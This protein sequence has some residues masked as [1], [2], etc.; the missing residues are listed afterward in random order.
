M[1]IISY[2][3]PFSNRFHSIDDFKKIETMKKVIVCL[4]TFFAGVVTLPILCM[5]G[6]A[7]FRYLVDRFKVIHLNEVDPNSTP[8]R[9]HRVAIERLEGGDVPIAVPIEEPAVN[10]VPPEIPEEE[11]AVNEVPPEIPEEE[12]AVNE[13]PPEIPEDEPAVYEVPTKKLAPRIEFAAP[14]LKKPPETVANTE[15]MFGLFLNDYNNMSLE[16]LQPNAGKTLEYLIHELNEIKK[17][18]E[19]EDL[20]NINLLLED[21]QSAYESICIYQQIRQLLKDDPTP[22]L[23]ASASQFLVE[24]LVANYK[25]T[26]SSGYSSCSAGHETIVHLSIIEKDNKQYVTGYLINRGEGIENHNKLLQ[27]LGDKISAYIRLGECLLTD[28]ENS[29]FL[30]LLLSLKITKVPEQSKTVNQTPMPSAEAHHNIRDFYEV[31]L[32][33]WPGKLEPLNRAPRAPQKGE[34]C[35]AKGYITMLKDRLPGVKGERIKL[36]LNKRILK[37]Y[38]KIVGI[39]SSNV[40]HIKHALENINRSQV[41]LVRKKA[42][43]E[44]SLFLFNLFSFSVKEKINLFINDQK[45][46]FTSCSK[47]NPSNMIDN[48]SYQPNRIRGKAFEV[49]TYSQNNSTLPKYHI[50]T[51]TEYLKSG[52]EIVEKFSKENQKLDAKII[53]LEILQ[54]IP[55]ATDTFWQNNVTKEH[56]KYLSILSDCIIKEATKLD[57]ELV[58]MSPNTVVFLLKNFAIMSIASKKF[59]LPN[60][61]ID[62]YVQTIQFA[63]QTVKSRFLP[64]LSSI[65]KEYDES[66]KELNLIR[67][68]KTKPYMPYSSIEKLDYLPYVILEKQPFSRMDQVMNDP[69]LKYLNSQLKTNNRFS[70]GEFGEVESTIHLY[71]KE[72]S[73]KLP[74]EFVNLR[75]QFHCLFFGL[76]LEGRVSHYD[77]KSS[78]RFDFIR[79]G[80][81]FIYTGIIYKETELNYFKLNDTKDPS[82]HIFISSFQKSLSEEFKQFVLDVVH[83]KSKYFIDKISKQNEQLQ[84][85]SNVNIEKN[86]SISGAEYQELISISLK[87]QTHFPRLTEYFT[88][89][90]WR[91]KDNRFKCLF[92]ML[93]FARGKTNPQI[94]LLQEVFKNNLQIKNQFINFFKTS[95]ERMHACGWLNEE[96]HLLWVYAHVLTFIDPESNLSVHKSS[97]TFIESKLKSLMEKTAKNSKDRTV[98]L[99]WIAALAPSF[100]DSPHTQN[101]LDYC[102]AA[103]EA[104]QKSSQPHSFERGIQ[105]D[106]DFQLLGKKLTE[107]KGSKGQLPIAIVTHDDFYFKKRFRSKEVLKGLFEFLGDDRVTYR[108]QIVDSELRLFRKFKLKNGV[109]DWFQLRKENPFG[110]K[111][112][113]PNKHPCDGGYLTAGTQNWFHVGNSDECIVVSINN[114]NI[115]CRI[116]QNNIEKVHEGLSPLFLATAY[117]SKHPLI[118]SILKVD[119][120]NYVLI[121][122]NLQDEI[123]EIELPHYNETIKRVVD[124]T[125]KINTWQ[126]TLHPGYILDSTKV[127][128]QLYPYDRYLILTQKKDERNQIVLLPN[129]I[130][131]GSR[132]SL[133]EEENTTKLN[134]APSFLHYQLNKKGKIEIPNDPER[135]VYLAYLALRIKNYKLCTQVINKLRKQ[136][137]R[138]GDGLGKVLRTLTDDQEHQLDCH[139]KAF[140]LKLQLTEL[141]KEATGI[142]VEQINLTKSALNISFTL[143]WLNE[144][145]A[146]SM[147]NNSESPEPILLKTRPGQGFIANFLYY[148]KIVRSLP[149]TNPKHKELLD[150]LRTSRFG[151][152]V[153]V[154]SLRR[155]LLTVSC[156][157][158]KFPDLKKLEEAI[159]GKTLADFLIKSISGLT[160]ISYLPEWSFEAKIDSSTKQT[161]SLLKNK[162]SATPGAKVN[163]LPLS[164]QIERDMDYIHLFD[165]SGYLYRQDPEDRKVYLRKEIAALTEMQREVYGNAPVEDPCVEKEYKRY[166]GGFEK[167][168]NHLQ[169]QLS[170]GLPH[171]QI[172]QGT[173]AAFSEDLQRLIREENSTLA[174]LK[175]KM[176][177]ILHHYPE[178]LKPEVACGLLTPL[179]LKELIFYFG[180]ED[181]SAITT[182][183]PSLGQE[184]IKNCKHLLMQYLVLSTN[185]NQMIHALEQLKEAQEL[186]SQSE[187]IFQVALDKVVGTLSEIRQ[188]QPLQDPTL[189]VF[190]Y[191][192]KL[193][194]RE[195]QITALK[196]LTGD[197]LQNIELEARTGFGKSK[198]LIPLW[199][200]L[201]SR[202]RPLTMMTVPQSLF[203]DQLKHLRKILGDSFDLSILPL[204]ITRKDCSNLDF[205]E[206]LDKKL[207]KAIKIKQILLI[208]INSLH[209]IATLAEKEALLECES[210]EDE[211]KCNA[212]HDARKKL[213]AKLS[214]FVD[215]SKEC[216]DIRRRYD[217][218]IGSPTAIPQVRCEKAH[219]FFEEVLFSSE[220]MRKWNFEFLPDSSKK[221]KA[222]ITDE[223]YTNELAHELAQKGLAWLNIPAEHRNAMLMNLKGFYTTACEAYF[224]NCTQDQLEKIEYVKNQISQFLKRTLIRD[225]DTRYGFN[226]ATQD[227]VAI[228]YEKGTP[229][230]QSQ[231]STVDDVINFTIQANLKHPFETQHVARYVFDLK[232]SFLDVEADELE[233]LPIIKVL[234]QL[235]RINRNIPNIDKLGEEH[236]ERILKVINDPKMLSVKL[237]FISAFVLPNI[238]YYQ[239]KISSTSFNLIRT[240][241]HVNAASGTVNP[242]TLPPKITPKQDSTAPINNLMSLWKNSQDKLFT[243]PAANSRAMLKKTL[244]D[245]SDY[246]VIVDAAGF[247]RELSQ[248]QIAE[249]ILEESASWPQPVNAVSFYDAKGHFMVLERNSTKPIPY[250]GTTV[251]LEEIF[252]F[253]R[254]SNSIGADTPMCSNAKGLITMSEK[255]PK[256]LFLQ[257]VGRMRGLQ[258]GQEAG[259]L[260]TEEASFAITGSKE[261][262]TLKPLLRYLTSK[263]GLKTGEDYAFSLLLYL[264]D[265]L[266][267]LFMKNI[268]QE[269]L[270]VRKALFDKMQKYLVITTQPAS[271]AALRTNLKNLPAKEAVE[272]LL[273]CY[274]THLGDFLKEDR[275][276]NRIINLSTIK[277][278]F[279]KYL[280]YSKLPK[281]MPS[282]LDQDV[283]SVVEV[284]ETDTEVEAEQVTEA[285]CETDQELEME[286]EQQTENAIDL[287]VIKYTPA[288]LKKWDGDYRKLFAEN[289]SQIGSITCFESPNISFVSLDA[290]INKKVRKP[291]YQYVIKRDARTKT[292]SIAMLDIYDAHKV[293]KRMD[294]EISNKSSL[295][296]DDYFVFSNNNIIASRAH[297]SYDK[298]NKDDVALRIIMKLFVGNNKLLLIEQNFLR[299]DNKLLGDVIQTARRL[300]LAW[301]HMIKL[302]ELET[303]APA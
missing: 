265:I 295:D 299:Q 88:K 79:N 61:L 69:E 148:Y 279:F 239:K 259:L 181:D 78:F 93:I 153:K 22:T 33:S 247:F 243:L 144:G 59:G 179:K 185:Q 202:K 129:R 137:S 244:Q 25:L 200:L 112:I 142:E 182:S 92:E 213:F 118:K 168:I 268:D 21:Y 188:Y 9:A 37:R 132:Q 115:L 276:L 57:Q 39:N 161:I 220:I 50:S 250:D 234:R 146:N 147:L 35:S 114:K 267:G 217:Y 172:H 210:K 72:F 164:D 143:E 100:S 126:S 230:P 62:Y 254:H 163:Q 24:K 300:S 128:G 121:W 111:Y 211:K 226:P 167:K 107:N 193:R 82:K 183:N 190:E 270:K 5:G 237:S 289:G 108:V 94:S 156:D 109:Q 192:A 49:A 30:E 20:E 292:Y 206:W 291:A 18:L 19:E 260:L 238:T 7:T 287:P 236:Y 245:H 165:D 177:A 48:N 138:W 104:I 180:K 252:T 97:V 160:I 283:I 40:Q 262:I 152:D 219:Q 99:H 204:E 46:R 113:T 296:K 251:P 277:A 278:E 208:S 136:P 269:P 44:E 11:P 71:A 15:L 216:F 135:A 203:Q 53:A 130:V 162:L 91:L 23:L 242:A 169:T 12:P 80:G 14:V 174:T 29:D 151:I 191:Y 173:L 280:D 171:Y 124:P 187:Q 34:T 290:S 240:L 166:E 273:D 224:K 8:A 288:P 232:K 36:I 281:M 67:T 222:N 105:L 133:R 28:L 170:S 66:L 51:I 157:P 194:L 45:V 140:E 257:A 75:Q 225:C 55:F 159:Q 176:L 1:N 264:D 42:V 16:E 195:D 154:E 116:T 233:K 196:D 198:V 127:V 228:P 54:T 255:T 90:L 87:S 70:I 272:L 139:P 199:I 27:V 303:A 150:L 64:N 38:I 41:R 275:Q 158:K 141:L 214:N 231:F 73:E 47:I 263:Q 186:S 241:P 271:L 83:N 149:K 123:V 117:D 261:P 229:Q 60:D 65:S 96:M 285:E 297:Q 56:V 302:A 294:K 205:I 89:Y 31:T 52:S 221:E 84:F 266:E 284:S 122:K 248:Q 253:I 197:D 58:S 110:E 212:L 246:R 102:K 13:V 134:A 178:Q 258:T 101:L 77:Q 86:E 209:N 120:P 293:L 175:A 189:L 301:P 95:I 43:S 3:N 74:L 6:V 98:L 286:M 68:D 103:Y 2:F 131:E 106:E 218:A 201:T 298:K 26:L 76:Y 119:D 227:R 155:Y 81:G 235:Q 256:D 32:T 207:D 274:L 85:Q 10:E 223:T 249:L 184:D 125:T 17:D 282:G 215:E 145:I 63:I 4:V